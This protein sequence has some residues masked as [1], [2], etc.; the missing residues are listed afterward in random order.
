MAKNLTVVILIETIV[1]V[2]LTG[3]VVFFALGNNTGLKTA[4]SPEEAAQK[5]INYINEKFMAG[6]VK[7]TLKS[8][9]E[10]SG[11]YKIQLQ[12][13][14]KEYTSYVTRDG[15]F[16]FPEAINLNPPEPIEFPKTAKPDVKLFVMSFCP[17][18]NQAEEML[19]PVVNL[20]K[21]KADFELHYIFYSNYASGYPEYCFDKENK[22]CSMHGIQELNQ[23]IR[24]LCVYKYQKDKFWDFVKEINQQATAQNVDNKWESV[25]Q[26]L[27]IDIQKIKNCEQNEALD[28]L[29]QEV[30]L[31]NN[32]YLVQDPTKH[33]GKELESISGSP[34]LVINGVI[35]D[36][37]RTPE[38]FKN[39]ICSAFDNPPEECNQTLTT[40][41]N[42]PLGS[43]K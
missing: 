22:Y 27:G 6:D 23:G 12:I 11:V 4:L 37:S 39:A 41:E 26:S 10:S 15:G 3:L 21:D 29:A 19:M 20:L 16:L 40:Q 5:A 30:E 1:I 9:E 25:A 33:G 43:C 28:L 17:F 38:D 8:V 2:A 31:T 32:E 36:G 14:D 13:G 18:G 34:T 42:A 7:A 24:E 35:Y